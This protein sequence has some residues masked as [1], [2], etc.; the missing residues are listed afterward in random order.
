MKKLICM[1]IIALMTI[2]V[3]APAYA[4]VEVAQNAGTQGVITPQWTYI[5]LI[6]PGLSINSLGKATCTGIA[7]VY[8][9]SH[10][11]KLTVNLQKST[12][13]GRSTITSWS[14]TSPPGSTIAALEE[15]YYV[16]H[17]TY[18][19]SNNV[20]VYNSSGTLLEDKTVYSDTVTY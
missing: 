11:V 3:A 7:Q 5:A 13:S 2:L 16:V 17:G 19:V 1:G 20:K 6:C 8:D 15:D 18:R 4:T 14:A 10:T 12:S 9:R